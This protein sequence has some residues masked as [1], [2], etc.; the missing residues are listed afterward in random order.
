MG[1]PF[2]DAA[3]WLPAPMVFRSSWLRVI[4]A[5]GGTALAPAAIPVVLLLGNHPPAPTDAW[6]LL[7]LAFAVVCACLAVWGERRKQLVLRAGSLSL[8]A[9]WRRREIA[10]ADITAVTLDRVAASRMVT[11]W[12]RDGK[13]HRASVVGRTKGL[14]K[15]SFDRDWH[16]IGQW[17]LANGGMPVEQQWTPPAIA[18]GWVPNGFDWR[19]Q[20]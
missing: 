16:L 12:T 4:I 3:G 20:A 2:A 19:P 6:D 7:P 5:A 9:G 14:V 18:S 13:P 15:Q 1:Q 10:A 17:W 11:I 8:R